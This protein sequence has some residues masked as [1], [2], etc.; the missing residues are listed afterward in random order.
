M[1]PVPLIIECKR[2]KHLSKEERKKFQE[3]NVY[4]RRLIA[5]PE[6]PIK[7]GQKTVIIIADLAYNEIMRCG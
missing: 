5:Y 6:N 4:G 3:W 1:E 2:N 7:R